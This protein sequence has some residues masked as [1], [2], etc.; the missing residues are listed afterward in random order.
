MDHEIHSTKLSRF[1]GG[2]VNLMLPRVRYLLEWVVF[3]FSPFLRRYG[4][5]VNPREPRS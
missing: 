1:H 4:I 5:Y 3:H 2:G